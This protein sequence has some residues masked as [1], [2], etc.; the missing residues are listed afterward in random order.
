MDH[1]SLGGWLLLLVVITLYVIPTWVAFGRGACARWG[2][3]LLNLLFGWT[4]LGWFA[5]LIWA[6]SSKTKTQEE[7]EQL[8]LHK[9]R[10]E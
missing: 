1:A 9:L 5:S 3:L 7:I 4:V 6:T 8:T 10:T 2:V